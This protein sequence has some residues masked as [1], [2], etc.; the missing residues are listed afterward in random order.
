MI[1]TGNT[2]GK[3]RTGAE[4]QEI[5]AAAEII[6]KTITIMAEIMGIIITSKNARKI[7]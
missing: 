6:V 2:A 5:I 7:K 4:N 3:T 1:L